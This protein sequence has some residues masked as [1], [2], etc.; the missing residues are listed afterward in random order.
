MI[1]KDEEWKFSRVVFVSWCFGRK[2]HM[3]GG[4]VSAVFLVFF[5]LE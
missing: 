4:D 2:Q 3:H 1:S 5:Q